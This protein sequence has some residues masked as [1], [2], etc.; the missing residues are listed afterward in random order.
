MYGIWLITH[1]FILCRVRNFLYF[2]QAPRT[3]RSS[4][5][6][7]RTQ[8]NAVAQQALIAHWQSIVKNLNNYLK[9]MKANY[10]SSDFFLNLGYLKSVL[11]LI[12]TRILAVTQYR[13]HLSW[14]GRFSLKY[15]LS[16]MSNYSTGKSSVILKYMLFTIIS[17]W[18]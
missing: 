2:T 6:K 11:S 16:S 10:V 8:A 17:F 14:S 9:I 13:F 18:I 4:L 5:V 7:G 12:Y 3:S 15:F 1:H